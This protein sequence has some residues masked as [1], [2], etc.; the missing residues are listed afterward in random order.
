MDENLNDQTSNG[1]TPPET[2]PEA[3]QVEEVVQ[4]EQ[5]QENTEDPQPQV[6]ESPVSTEE[7]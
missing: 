7:G 5:V 6:E 2:P 1:G 3:P 4:E